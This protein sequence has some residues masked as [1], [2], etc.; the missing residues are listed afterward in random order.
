[1]DQLILL[2]LYQLS[3]QIFS[4]IFG[5]SLNDALTLAVHLTR[6]VF[7]CD[8]PLR[9]QSN[10]TGQSFKPIQVSSFIN[11]LSTYTCIDT[12]FYFYIKMY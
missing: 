8:T 7:Q 9:N 3:V 11:T 12:Y 6:F 2:D 4:L 1:M 10:L 5:I